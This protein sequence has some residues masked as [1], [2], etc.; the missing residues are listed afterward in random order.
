M[1]DPVTEVFVNPYT[2]E[3]LGGRAWGE[4]AWGGEHV[5]PMTYVLHHS[6]L[7]GDLDGWGFWIMGVV[8][9]L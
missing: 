7:L 2:A 8:V 3:V 6:L 4:V 5:M 1:E 9:L